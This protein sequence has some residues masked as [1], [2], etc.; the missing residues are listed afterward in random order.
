MVTCP[1]AGPGKSAGTCNHSA[2]L[3]FLLGYVVGMTCPTKE[4]EHVINFLGCHPYI[5]WL[6][7]QY[8][9]TKQEMGLSALI[10]CSGLFVGTWRTYCETKYDIL[11]FVVAC[12][13][14]NIKSFFKGQLNLLNTNSWWCW[15]MH[16]GWVHDPFFFGGIV[17]AVRP[18]LLKP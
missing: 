14:I 6:Q 12:N 17:Y 2:L 8:S 11:I 7:G 16:L 9:V 5:A 3:Y 1:G 13:E 18:A 4:P 15:E 10:T